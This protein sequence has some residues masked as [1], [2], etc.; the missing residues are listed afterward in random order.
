MGQGSWPSYILINTWYKGA[1]WGH[2]LTILEGFTGVLAVPLW[3]AE[4][5]EA[6]GAALMIDNLG[7]C[8]AST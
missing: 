6:G 5:Q 4:I 3:A 2:P 7:L 1:R 8:Y